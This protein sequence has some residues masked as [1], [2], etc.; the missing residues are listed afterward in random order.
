MDYGPIPSPSLG[1]GNFWRG[2]E[3][4]DERLGLWNIHW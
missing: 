1:E 3:S 4:F 2:C